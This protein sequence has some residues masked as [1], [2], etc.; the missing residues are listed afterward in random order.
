MPR[1]RSSVVAVELAAAG[2]PGSP[3]SDGATVYTEPARD[4]RR[5][6]VR[7]LPGIPSAHGHLRSH[8]CV[9]S[10]RSAP[11]RLATVAAAVQKQRGSLS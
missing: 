4:K 8:S 3:D 2:P 1:R 6:P 7:A 5:N 10:V 9:P 11:M